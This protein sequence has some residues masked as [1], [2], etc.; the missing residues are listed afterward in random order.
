M[1]ITDISVLLI[2]PI[3]PPA[4]GDSTWAL[5][6]LNYCKAM[7]LHVE[8]INTSV[9]GKRA[10]TVNTS[11]SLID[12]IRRT[13]RIWSSTIKILRKKNIDVVHMNTNCSPRGIIRDYIS[14]YIIKRF[15]KP[16]VIH[17]RCN[18]ADQIGDSQIGLKYFIKLSQISDKVIV[19]NNKSLEYVKKMADREGVIVPNFIENDFIT[20]TKDIREKVK[21]VIFV[22]HVKNTKGIREIIQTAK[23]FSDIKFII[24]G[25]LTDDYMKYD[26]DIPNINYIGSVDI[27]QIKT[28]LDK[29]DVF[30][31]PTYTEGFSNALLEAMARGL[32]IITTDVGANKDMIE[33][34]GGLIVMIESSDELIE[35]IKTIDNR[36]LRESMSRW[37]IE[38]VQ[39]KYKIN[40][41]ILNLFEIYLELSKKRND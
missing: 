40:N 38:K 7:N 39:Q 25:P 21:E 24:A 22:G 41:V 14:A 10:L 12:E 2:S 18:I 11:F 36:L 15:K 35:A 26:K 30:L 32:P 4:G 33:D 17:C 9:I 27:K 29:A 19:L 16:I 20:E 13:Y 3:P 31:F 37:N 8:H 6:Y 28:H 23:Q 1:N 5:K 34:K